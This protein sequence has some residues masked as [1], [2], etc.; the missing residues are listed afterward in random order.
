MKRRGRMKKKKKE[1]KV[2]QRMHVRRD[3]DVVVIAGAHR[4]KSGKVLKVF[5]D[6]NRVIVEA[7]N[8]VKRHTRATQTQ[9]G[10]IVEKEA[11][12]NASNVKKTG[13]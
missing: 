7:V 5:P 6:T 8:L 2:K 9:Q 11:P 12:I 1:T 10:G 3:Y 4:G 13:A